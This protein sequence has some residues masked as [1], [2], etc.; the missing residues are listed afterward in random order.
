M[1]SQYPANMEVDETDEILLDMLA[2]G[3]CTQGYLVTETDIP[4][5]KIHD[6]LKMYGKMGYAK[7]LHENTALW[8]LVKDPREESDDG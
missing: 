6:R 1:A 5:Y 8:E 4:R 3:R 2:E 7:N